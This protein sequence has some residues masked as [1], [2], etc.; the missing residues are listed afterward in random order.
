MKSRVKEVEGR[1]YWELQGRGRPTRG[2]SSHCEGRFARTVD[3]LF[4]FKISS[5]YLKCVSKVLGQMWALLALR[6]CP[7]TFETHFTSLSRSAVDCA[8]S[9]LIKIIGRSKWSAPHPI[10]GHLRKYLLDR[11]V[12]HI[13]VIR[14]RSVVTRFSRN[15]ILSLTKH[16]TTA[17]SIHY[18]MPP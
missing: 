13:V 18:A 2:Q 16:P 11:E 12:I 14:S 4:A 10:N 15:Q 3:D 5:S 8:F 9:V 7:R 6:E 1:H 17:T